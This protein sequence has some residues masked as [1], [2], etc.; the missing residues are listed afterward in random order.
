L[1]LRHAGCGRRRELA[2]P[3]SGAAGGGGKAVGRHKRRHTG[4]AELGRVAGGQA[5]ERA[6]RRRGTNA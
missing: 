1:R 2:A 5:R 3:S 6:R 4:G